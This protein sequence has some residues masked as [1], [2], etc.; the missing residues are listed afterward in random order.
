MNYSYCWCPG[1][2]SKKQC[3]YKTYHKKERGKYLLNEGNYA[4]ALKDRN[5]FKWW[6]ETE[7]SFFNN[8]SVLM[9]LCSFPHAIALIPHAIALISHATTLIPHAT[10]LIPHAITLIPH[11]I[12]LIP[13]A[14]ALIPHAIALIPHAIAYNC[15]HPS[16]NCM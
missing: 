14:I 3:Y 2:W 5:Q 8:I 13:H 1:C 16:Y 9:Q 6:R 10:T 4:T 7:G 15:A 11:A 12:A